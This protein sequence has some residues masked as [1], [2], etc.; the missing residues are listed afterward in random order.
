MIKVP[1]PGGKWLQVK[2][3][4]E[5]FFIAAIAFPFFPMAGENIQ[6]LKYIF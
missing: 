2:Q 4:P 5:L 1:L 6:G 3:L